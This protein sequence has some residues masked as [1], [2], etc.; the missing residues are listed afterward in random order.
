MAS[1]LRAFLCGTAAISVLLS[2]GFVGSAT[3]A[4]RA[5]STA[6]LV[7]AY[8]FDS[9]TSVADASGSGNNG[10]TRNTTWAAAGKYGGALSFNGTSS[11]VTVPDSAS[12][13]F[14][15]GF[16]VEAWVDPATALGT[17]WQAV[18]VK[19]RTGG[20]VFG[21]YANSNRKQPGGLTFTGSSEKTAYG[22][23]QVAAGKWTH[24]AETFDGSAVRLYV[25][26]TLVSTMV[27]AGALPSSTSP[28]RFGG[29]AV[30]SEFFR[31]LIDEAR[32]YNR[33]LAAPEISSDM[34]KPVG[35]AADTQAPTVPSA[36]HVTGQTMTTAS[37]AWTASSDNVGV[38]AYDVYR[39]GSS[40]GSSSATSYTF[41][42][43]VCGTSY[44]VAVDAVDAAGNRSAQSTLTAQTAACPPPADTQAPT[45]PA[46][47]TVASATQT[48]VGLSWSSSTDNV[49]VAG[50]GLYKAG[51]AAGTTAST[52]SSF[53][54]LACGTSYQ[55][56]VDAYDAAANRSPRS[57]MQVSTSACPDT[58][59]PSA[60]GGLVAASIGQTSVGLNW[61]ASTDST[62]VVGYGVYRA[63]TQVGSAVSTSTAVSGL[64]CATSYSLGV[65]AVDAAGNRSA[66]ATVT[67]TTAACS[68]SGTG[69]S[70]YVA[71]GGSDS[72]PCTAAQPCATFNRAVT[73]AS[74]GQV[75]QVA[76]GSYAAQSIS[77]V[78][79]GPAAV[80]VQPTTGATVSVASLDLSGAYVEVRSMTV[81]S[82]IGWSVEPSAR[83]ATLRDI[84]SPRGWVVGN[85]VTIVGG[86][87]GPV[88]SCLT[89]TED[90]LQIWQH[91]SVASS[92]VTIDGVYIHDISDH[93][94]SCAGYANAGIHDDCV[95]ILAGHYT[96][97]RNSTFYNCPTSNVIARPYLDTLDHLTIE[98]NVFNPERR[99]GASLSI[100]ASGDSCDSV[101]IQYNTL[102]TA[103]SI[104]DCSTSMIVRGN[105]LPYARGGLCSYDKTP[106]YSYNVWLSGP[107]CGPTDRVCTPAFVNAAALDFHLALT[108]TCAKDHGDPLN[109]PA[110]D[111]D[112]GSRPLGLAPDAGADETG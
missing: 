41:A 89:G 20:V 99:G 75:V 45:G 36:A 43:L 9:S 107:A 81:T 5:A 13:H 105:I 58:S 72:G 95:Q 37:L 67:V 32:V 91:S 112:G 102:I 53:S 42:G 62:G 63:G 57:L 84:H 59:A 29:D 3:A 48:S 78:K 56:A 68:G 66:P 34:A 97:I 30:W 69:A 90:G 101:V 44:S 2:V 110:T 15:G 47:L 70:F 77:A 17:A 85:Y 108:D 55:L 60:P 16:T 73:L 52:S 14:T 11:W 92:H 83:Y 86:E 71:L 31:G 10:T 49:A 93:D 23:S 1:A 87:I 111:F 28:L 61:S 22:T 8:S 54:G 33:P 39:A 109:Y 7:A 18:A 46:A 6:G 24:L 4:T 96:T 88:D 79:A 94:N 50:Y 27:A 35:T 40:V 65:D 21:L 100:G 51:A 64:A 80:I 104:F 26:G 98:N 38:S 74:P 19:E 76:A 103:S 25:N 12:L 106:Q 82:G